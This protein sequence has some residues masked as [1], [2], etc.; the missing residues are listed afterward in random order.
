VTDE[1]LLL[2]QS[3][4]WTLER[5]LVTQPNAFCKLLCM[6]IGLASVA[7]AAR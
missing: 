6:F 7:V 1:E 3:P 2:H 5:E 4:V